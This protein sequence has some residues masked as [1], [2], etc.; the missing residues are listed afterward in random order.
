MTSPR[1][2]GARAGVVVAILAAL[3]SAGALAACRDSGAPAGQS[4]PS[5]L[6]A[7]GSPSATTAGSPPAGPTGAAAG[8]VPDISLDCLDGGGSVRL[9]ALGRPAVVN[10]WAA[11][12][13]PCRAELPAIQQYAASS[14]VTVIGVDTQD[15]GTA[16]HA[17]I[18]DY[19]LTYP[20]LTDPSRKLLVA[21]DRTA[22]PAT[23]FVDADGGLRYVYNEGTPLTVARLTALASQYLG[24]P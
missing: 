22:L 16:A 5:C 21:V 13:D 17:A 10:L 3:A 2:R 19:G 15:T 8:K 6:P 12:C 23:L 14:G 9:A 11:W 4:A 7:T 20:Q 18:D 1:S 24:V